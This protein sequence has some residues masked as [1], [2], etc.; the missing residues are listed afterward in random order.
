MKL[1]RILPRPFAMAYQ[2]WDLGRAE[3]EYEYHQAVAD[4]LRERVQEGKEEL[5]RLKE[6][7]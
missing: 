1:T 6:R 7:R 4:V 3:Q 2:E 5:A